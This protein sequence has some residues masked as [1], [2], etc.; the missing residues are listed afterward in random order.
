MKLLSKKNTLLKLDNINVSY[1]TVSALKDISIQLYENE[2]HAIVGEHAA[3]K[4]TLGFVLSGF[5]QPDTGSIYWKNK[6]YKN[7]TIQST[8]K[9]G[10][11]IVMQDHEQ[12]NQLSVAENFLINNF[13]LNPLFIVNKPKVQQEVGVFLKSID[14]NIDPQKSMQNISYSERV[15]LDILKSIYAKPKL[16]ILD[17][18]LEKL[19][20]VDLCKV[21][22]IL[23]EL[24]ENG[25]S[26]LFITHNID[27]LYEIADRVTILRNSE[28]LIT[29]SIKNI[30]KFSLIKLAY[31]QVN[32]EENLKDNNKEFYELLKYNQAILESLPVNL[33]VIDK[34]NN[35]KLMNEHAKIF[36]KAEYKFYINIFLQDIFQEQNG[37]IISMIYDLIKIGTKETV[38][39]Q[40]LRIDTH[41]YVVNITTYPL[42][43]GFMDIG[44]MI[45]IED[46]SVQEKMRE[47]IILSEKLASVGLLAAGVAHEINNPLEIIYNYLDFIKMKMKDKT[48]IKTVDNLEEEINSINHIISSL[49]TF[50]KNAPDHIETFD[51]NELIRKMISLIQY[52]AINQKIK[53]K[54]SKSKNSLKIEANKTEIR[55]VMLNLIKNSFEAMPH[56]GELFLETK[57]QNENYRRE[58]LIIVTDTGIS[59]DKEKY[60]DIFL[61]FYSTKNGEGG[62][63]GLGLSV[64]YGIITKYNGTI[65]VENLEKGGC[66][67]IIKLPLSS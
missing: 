19:T 65:L 52:N 38:F 57:E 35:V 14:F 60:N 39:N 62:S 45:I 12:F 7:Y 27:N 48:L 51:I 20:K 61:P 4:S 47:K 50:S 55:Q 41:T 54:F 24:K 49:I 17:E 40:L 5:V 21:V 11:E 10:I 43:D 1:T 6:Q 18:S 8:K 67:F 22:K 30:D 13:S 59:I 63:L 23:K 36:F 29:D 26:I 9:L 25:T 37:E 56:G 32:Q 16:L 44:S 31:T 58:L 64:S 2:I 15:L 66:Q 42:N 33:I 53:I 3:G 34:N 28:I 46:I